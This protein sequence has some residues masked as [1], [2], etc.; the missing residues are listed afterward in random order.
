MVVE[1]S[2]VINGVAGSGDG[3]VQWCEMMKVR[4]EVGGQY[5]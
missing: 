4:S 3:G 5:P 1:C 2:E